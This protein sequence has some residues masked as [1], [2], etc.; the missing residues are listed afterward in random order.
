MK[1]PLKAQNYLHEEFD[2]LLF[3]QE[4]FIQGAPLRDEVQD[5][6]LPVEGLLS[7]LLTTAALSAVS[8]PVLRALASLPGFNFY[9][10]LNVKI[11]KN[12]V[13]IHG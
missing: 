9:T 4:V 11:Y 3:P 2:V 10:D 5:L 12:R 6:P 7:F 1:R 8:E 13:W